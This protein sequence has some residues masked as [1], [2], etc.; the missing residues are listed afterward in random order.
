VQQTTSGNDKQGWSSL[1]ILH[2]YTTGLSDLKYATGEEEPANSLSNSKAPGKLKRSWPPKLVIL[3]VKILLI[4]GSTC[5]V[6][7][8]G[9]IM[10]TGCPPTSP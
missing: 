8:K 2:A 7:V 9:K 3:P 1:G 10:K 4:I 5:D 6:I